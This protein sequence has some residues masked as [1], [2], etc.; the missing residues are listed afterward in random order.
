[1]RPDLPALLFSHP[2]GRAREL[3]DADLPTLQSFFEANPAYFLSV[4]GAAPRAD[5][6]RQEF[7]DRPPAGMPYRSVHVIGCFDDA[8]HLV[9]IASILTD[10]LAQQVWH[11]GLFIVATEL[12][13]SG[14]AST[15][16]RGLEQWM[17]DSGARWIRL[18]VVAGNT[19]AER[20]WARMG[21]TEVRRRNGVQTGT[22]TN[23]IRV[24]VK[25]LG[26]AGLGE[27]LQR[28]E[29]DRPDSQLP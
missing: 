28:V 7:D 24:M 26:D 23:T 15:I 22:L 25:G 9:A 11:I 5:E 6:A 16:Y 21:Y 10:L 12:H 14:R 18:G 29:R 13:G 27:Y 3:R 4:N 2:G 8:D 1:M 17:H 20:F 19:R